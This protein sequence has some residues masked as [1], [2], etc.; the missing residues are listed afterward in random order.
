MS[1]Q[2][3]IIEYIEQGVF[4]TAFVLE[5]NDTRRLRI[6]NQ[7]GRETNLPQSRIVHAGSARVAI[8]DSREARQA[9][10]ED[11]AARRAGLAADIDLEELWSVV[12]EEAGEELPAD[13]LAELCFGGSPDDDQAAAFLRAV[14]VDRLFFKYK[15]SRLLVHT[16]DTV[17]QLREKARREEERQKLLQRGAAILAALMR[18]APNDGSPETER[19]LE[20]VKDYYLFGNDAEDAEVARQL[21]KDAGL[22][23]PHDPFHLL[24]QAGVWDGN[25][26]IGLLRQQLPVHFS[27]EIL[28]EAEGLRQPPAEVFLAAG[29]RDLRQL[30]LLTIDGA[31]TRDRDD[32]L[33]IEQT[34]DGFR[35]GVHI[36]NVAWYVRPDSPLFQEAERRTTSIYFADA[37]IPMLPQSLSEDLCSLLENK[38]RPALSF[39]AELSASGEI[40]RSEIVPSVVRVKRQLTYEQADELMG[41]EKELK[42]LYVLSEVLKR[43]R[44]AAGALILPFP[45][46]VIQIEGGEVVRVGLAPVDTPGRSTVAEFMVLANSIAAQYLAER[47]VPGL[48]RSQ[49][50]PGQRLVREPQRDLYLNYRQRKHLAPGLLSTEP[51]P[52]SGVG[53]AQYTT[54][55][56]PIRRFLDLV[57]QHQLLH[58]L[59]GGGVLFP[60]HRLRD[61]AGSIGQTTSRVN[62]VRQQRHR[63]WLLRFLE[64]QVGRRFQAL[65]TGKGPRKVQVLLPEFL[66]D[67]ELP[68]NRAMGARP[69]DTVMVRLAKAN[70]L[71]GQ[72]RL[73]W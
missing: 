9:Y 72:L 31:Q 27:A 24:V 26:N 53:V 7:K 5:D 28:R 67:G 11:T 54:V 49:G 63:Y 73:E 23:G 48:F 65:I 6:I 37:Q 56:S 1:L 16:G 3:K 22:H 39:L 60:E 13:F 25:E 42:A 64:K 33:H 55:T 20:L 15:E 41:R 61:F 44:V 47:A 43:R 14:F 29:Y 38:E 51:L 17:E 46:V 4:L 34:G 36:A 70:A 58:Q 30:A 35:V 10:L 68:P 50:Q 71:D 57:I 12:A 40:L 69:G 32:A 8:P 45:D 19:C 21:L 2:S 66:L 59:N 52:H 18:G 62:L